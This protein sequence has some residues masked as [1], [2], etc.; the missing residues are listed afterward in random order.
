MPV[1]EKETLQ[2][3]KC[4]ELKE[5]ARKW[6]VKAKGKKANYVDNI[7]ARSLTMNQYFGQL[8]SLQKSVQTNWN[9]DPAPIHDHYRTHFNSIDLV[10]R[11]W[12]AVEEHHQNQHWE[13]KMTL[14][15]LRFAV[16]NS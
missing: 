8:K 10:D 9:I 11:K 13:S 4:D 2:S 1:F 12:N 16:L 14:T 3:M 7:A 5:L 15:I 6:K